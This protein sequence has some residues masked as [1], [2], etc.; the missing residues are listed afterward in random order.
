MKPGEIM[1]VEV[2]QRRLTT[3]QLDKNTVDHVV[4]EWARRHL[5]RDDGSGGRGTLSLRPVYRSEDATF[6]TDYQGCL[7]TFGGPGNFGSIGQRGISVRDIAAMILLGTL[8]EDCA[9]TLTDRSKKITEN[10]QK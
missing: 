3:I 10:N 7:K 2:E 4:M 5:N 8:P 9:I 1:Q 6:G